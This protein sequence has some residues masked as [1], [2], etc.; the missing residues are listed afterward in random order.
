MKTGWLCLLLLLHCPL[1]S[2]QQRPLLT[3]PVTPVR[4]GH[5]LLDI[6]FEFLED[7]QFPFS[8]LRGD[9]TRLGVL[10]LRVGAGDAVEVQLLGSLQNFLNI[11]QRQPAPNSPRLDFSGDSTSD[12]GDFALATK[13]RLARESGDRPALGF[14]FG[15]ELPNA[16]NES[17]L[18]NDQTNAFGSFLIEKNI[19]PVTILANLG[20]EI[21]GDPSTTGSQ[22]D[23]LAYGLAILYPVNSRFT[24]VAETH[25]RAGKGGIGTEERSLLRLG[26]QIRAGGLTWDVGALWGTRSTDPDW[27][28]VLGVS[29]EIPFPLLGF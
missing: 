4:K 20:L 23:L 17:G 1:T 21:L 27:G 12:F 11:D 14:R 26:S 6:G 25:G 3:E 22:D 19:A 7:A 29:R 8:G 28:L 10:G 24:L 9:L 18:G 5:L 13:V 15:V 16:S 2:A